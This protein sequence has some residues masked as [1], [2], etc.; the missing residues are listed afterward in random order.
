MGLWADGFH[1]R[2]SRADCVHVSSWF[3]P[4]V[5][6]ATGN[7]RGLSAA[8]RGRQRLILGPWTHGERGARVAG[9]VD[10]GPEAPV[11]SWA[12]DWLDYQLRHFDAVTRGLPNDEPSVRVF[13][14][15][16]GSGAAD[17]GGAAGSWR[18]L[19]HGC[20][21]AGAGGGAG[22]VAFAQ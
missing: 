8:G 13:V 14:M 20:R 9:D 10:F 19:D 16:G 12:G 18:A 11:G 21:L 7:Y 2:Y 3:D 22:G 15:G 17:G 1:H 5:S 4:Y 6:T